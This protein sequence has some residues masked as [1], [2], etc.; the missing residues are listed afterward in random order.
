METIE[1]GKFDEIVRR[2]F[3]KKKRS[4]DGQVNLCILPL[5]FAFYCP[6]FC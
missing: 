5:S 4:I 6:H 2:G 1:I 3:Q